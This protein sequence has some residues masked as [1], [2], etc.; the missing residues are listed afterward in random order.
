MRPRVTVGDLVYSKNIVL[1][2]TYYQVKL[3]VQGSVYI[4]FFLNGRTVH[5]HL[6]Q[7]RAQTCTTKS[8]DDPVVSED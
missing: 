3:H 7:L 1:G 8:R 6:D 5:E 4:Q 2:Q